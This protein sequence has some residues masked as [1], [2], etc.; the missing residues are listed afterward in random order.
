M[1]VNTVECRHCGTRTAADLL[2]SHVAERCPRHR[3]TRPRNDL[4]AM[5]GAGGPRTRNGEVP[6]PYSEALE[7]RAAAAGT[8]PAPKL[9]RD[10]D[11]TPMPW[12]SALAARR[13]A[14]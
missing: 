1:S 3:P 12:S 5:R 14:R 11:G 10:A 2:E 4:A 7:M 8:P 13:E 9:L 6:R